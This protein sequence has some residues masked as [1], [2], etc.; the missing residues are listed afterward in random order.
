MA[1]DPDDA[2]VRHEATTPLVSGVVAGNIVL[3]QTLDPD[4]VDGMSPS[5]SRAANLGVSVRAF[6]RP[7][8]LPIAEAASR[9]GCSVR[10]LQRLAR[11]G[12]ISLC[13]SRSVCV[14]PAG[15]SRST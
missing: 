10:T 4:Q 8:F 6:K 5:Q 12:R 7:E 3:R 14:R 1:M 13:A 9:L 11:D 2:V 15:G